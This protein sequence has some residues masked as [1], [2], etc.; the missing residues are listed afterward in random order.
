MTYSRYSVIVGAFLLI[1]GCTHP[2][3]LTN[4]PEAPPRGP[5]IAYPIIMGVVNRS[6]SV[7][8]KPIMIEVV[9]AWRARLGNV[10]QVVYPYTGKQEV[11]LVAYVDVTPTYRGVWTNFLV[12]FPGYLLFAPYWHGYSYHADIAIKV[13]F[14]R[15]SDGSQLGRFQWQH[16]YEFKQADAGRTW[17]QISWFEIGVI[18]FIGGFV[19]TTYDT[20]QTPEFLRRARLS[21]RYQVTYLLDQ[22][23]SKLP[24]DFWENLAEDAEEQPQRPH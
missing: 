17:T 20:D 19:A 11:D 12:N 9:G 24:R 5:R 1:A 22:K 13:D 4:I 23:L 15:A 21:Y 7:D 2:M 10:K 14:F 8:S 18:A 3:R 16:D 6:G